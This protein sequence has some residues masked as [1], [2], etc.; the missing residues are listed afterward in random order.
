MSGTD[1][2]PIDLGRPS[3]RLPNGINARG[4]LYN[5]RFEHDACGIGFVAQKLGERSHRVLEL[6]LTALCNHAHRGAVAADGKSG[7]GAGV[8][9]QLPY[10][11]I[12]RHLTHQGITPP[13]RDRLA[14][15]MIFLPRYNPD[16]RERSR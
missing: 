15:G 2:Q 10:E 12:A 14:V 7:D 13:E 11:I 1:S 3:A 16:H 6:A 4:S 8:L 9:T 5:P